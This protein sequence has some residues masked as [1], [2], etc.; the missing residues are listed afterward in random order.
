M[1]PFLSQP[2]SLAGRHVVLEVDCTSVIYGWDKRQASGDKSASILLRALHLISSYLACSI[3]MEHRIRRTSR[4]SI[5]ADDLT[6]EETTSRPLRQRVQAMESPH[7]SPALANW[8]LDPVEDW[9]LAN[10]ILQDVRTVCE[11]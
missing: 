9:E 3:H 5:L 10:R 11:Q 1:L 7:L 8:L 4:G 6:R 2:A